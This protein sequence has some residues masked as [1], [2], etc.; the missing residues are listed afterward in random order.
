M[1]LWQCSSE[2]K[3]GKRKRQRS[4]V[5]NKLKGQRLTISW[6]CSCGNIPGAIFPDT[7]QELDWL[8]C[9]SEKKKGKRK[10][11]RSKVGNKLKGQRLT[12][13][14]QCSCGN[15]PAAIFPDTHQELDW[16]QCFSGNVPQRKRKEKE[17]A[18]GQ[19]LAINSKVKG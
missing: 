16:L 10:S 2:K 7:H 15:I 8:Q 12:I 17:K 13:S 19:R 5:G 14:W 4:K 3:K 9:S 1:F 18:K 6:Q 11:Q